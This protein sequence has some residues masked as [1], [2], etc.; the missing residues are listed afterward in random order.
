MGLKDFFILYKKSE[1]SAHLKRISRE[2]TKVQ[3]ST[4][5]IEIHPLPLQL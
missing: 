5:L 1:L 4:Q 2:S 3:K